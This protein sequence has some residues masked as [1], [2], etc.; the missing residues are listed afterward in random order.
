MLL[1][2]L[3]FPRKS[4]VHKF[5][6]MNYCPRHIT[7]FIQFCR[8]DPF[9]NHPPFFSVVRIVLCCVH[10]RFPYK[11]RASTLISH[12]LITQ[13][14]IDDQRRVYRWRHRIARQSTI[15]F[16]TWNYY[17]FP[18]LSR[19]W[20]RFQFLIFHIL[21]ESFK[22]YCAWKI[23]IHNCRSLSLHRWS[24]SQSLFR[25]KR[26]DAGR[27]IEFALHVYTIIFM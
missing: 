7:L 24:G 15:D 8:L 20:R 23:Q 18:P 26:N 4:Q 5:I 12:K 17:K 19:H 27:E 11:M 16:H 25:D 14:I 6:L 1:L 9:F 3:F 13:F 21:S 10:A 2:L 22:I